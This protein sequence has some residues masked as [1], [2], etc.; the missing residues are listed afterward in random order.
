MGSPA[1]KEQQDARDRA[2]LP[3]PHSRELPA[4]GRRA[5]HSLPTLAWRALS[6]LQDLV[7]AQPFDEP[8]AGY[9]ARLLQAAREIEEALAELG[10]QR[11]AAAE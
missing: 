2:Q 11:R 1:A 5:A 9:R 6:F 8:N 10:E 7:E 4:P 3:E